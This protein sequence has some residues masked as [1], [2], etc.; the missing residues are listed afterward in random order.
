M[1]EYSIS[2]HLQRVYIFKKKDGRP[3]IVD[4]KTTKSVKTLCAEN[5]KI[6]RLRGTFV[7]DGDTGL[8]PLTESECSAI[9]K[10]PT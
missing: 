9:M 6:Q 8:R 1:K 2:R 4:R 10:F 7:S 3:E 5:H